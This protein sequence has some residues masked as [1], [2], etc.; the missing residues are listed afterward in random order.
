[1]ND[2][3]KPEPFMK[4]L[5]QALA[6][7]L[8]CSGA[9][10]A[11][12]PVLT[13]GVASGFP[14]YQYA[15]DGQ[16]AGLDVE[17]ARAVAARLGMEPRFVQSDWD[18]VVGMLR[19]GRID[20]IAG[21][22][23]N[24]FRL[25]YFDFTRPYAKRHDVV[26][27]PENSAARSVEDLYGQRISGDRHSYVELLWKKEGIHQHIRITQAATKEEAMRL[28]VEGKTA[29]AIMPLEVGRFLAR[30][31]GAGVRVLATPD[32]GSDV[33]MAVRKGRTRLR[34]DADAALG[35]MRTDGALDALHRKW[36]APPAEDRPAA[37]P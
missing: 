22:E 37:R 12:D 36:L 3:P 14:P 7:I 16:P 10:P 11:Q 15:I 27:V 32:P 23:V 2:N 5:L 19:I 29:A 33:A 1:V 13:I 24:E 25:A 35:S 20:I 21:M 28:L 26:F 6:I 18:R 8:L 31:S 4:H 9:S 34:E 30:E 17:V